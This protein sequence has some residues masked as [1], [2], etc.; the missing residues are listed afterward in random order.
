MSEHK[1]T[2]IICIIA[3]AATLIV[4][5]VLMIGRNAADRS[6]NTEN[7]TPSGYKDNADDF[8]GATQIVFSGSTAKINGSGAYFEN[9]S[10]NIA[11]AGSYVLSGEL[12]NGCVT[13]KTNKEA[14]VAILLNGVYI[15]AENGAGLI[16]E[17]AKKVNITIADNTENSITGGVFSGESKIDGAIYSNDDLVFKGGGSLAVNSENGHGI[18]CND[19]LVFAGGKI[20]VKAGTDAVHANDS[21]KIYSTELEL[22]AGD[23][24]ITVS[25]DNNT[26]LLFIESGRVNISS[27]YEGLE[28]CTVRINGGDI[29][30][31]PEDDGLNAADGAR[32]IEINGGNVSV[33]NKNGRD[34]DG[35]DSNGDIVINGGNVFISVPGNGTCLALD[36]GGENGGV[37]KINGGTVAAFG[38]SMMAEKVSADS[39]QGFIM[40][41]VSYAADTEI[42]LSKNGT[43]L[44]GTVVP[45][46][47]SL[48]LLSAP[49]MAVSDTVTV[50]ANGE[51]TEYTVDSS[52][53]GGMT[54]PGG[55]GGGKDFGGRGERPGGFGGNGEVPSMPE[56]EI[57]P[58][59]EGEMPSMRKGEPPEPPGGFGGM[60]P[61]DGESPDFGGEPPRMPDGNTGAASV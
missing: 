43:E 41:S 14:E 40:K 31:Y 57:P 45:S 21:V 13:V 49:G 44:I 51:S 17:Q 6:G 56:G 26:S 16:A 54:A 29:T 19:D 10:L 60:E 11:V 27:C 23:D 24:G 7:T 48:M 53:E 30:V 61:P 15:S 58:M 4:T 18:V 20:S 59:A 1:T 5:V 37:C 12:E 42:T 39:E 32:L 52:F 25:N 35:F 47:F 8:S 9:G 38:G 46:D 50:T 2:D 34:A 28:A 33:I 55:F 22:S 3:I 36:Y